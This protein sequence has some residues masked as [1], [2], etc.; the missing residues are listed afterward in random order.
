[1]CRVPPVRSRVM[2]T[3]L[4]LLPSVYGGVVV[5]CGSSCLW[6]VADGDARASHLC[7]QRD[8]KWFLTSLVRS[9]LAIGSAVVGGSLCIPVAA[10]LSAASLPGIPMWLGTQ[11]TVSWTS[12]SVRRF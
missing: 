2:A 1:M 12:F 8:L 6:N 3:S 9:S 4:Y 10:S 7:C 5:I 11:V